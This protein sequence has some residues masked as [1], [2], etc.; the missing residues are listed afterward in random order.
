MRYRRYV[1]SI[2]I[3]LYTVAVYYKSKL[4]ATVSTFSTDD[5][6]MA[7]V[8]GAKAA[9][10]IAFIL[11]DVGFS[12]QVPTKLFCDNTSSIMMVKSNKP[13]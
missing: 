6:F 1:G 12:I 2:F 13:I 3:T 9:R 4:Q 10:Y 11:K 7:V 5:E 8:S